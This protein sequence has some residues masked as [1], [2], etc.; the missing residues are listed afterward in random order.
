[1]HLSL[2]VIVIMILIMKPHRNEWTC[3]QPHCGVRCACLTFRH[4]CCVLSLTLS[5]IV[6]SVC[7]CRYFCRQKSKTKTV[8]SSATTLQRQV[9][10]LALPV[11]FASQKCVH[12]NHTEA[13]GALDS[14][15]VCLSCV[16]GFGVGSTRVTC[17]STIR[18][19]LR[20]HHR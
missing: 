15:A 17:S 14:P 20:L 19:W 13:S 12:L 6:S 10:H 4:L 3:Q 16:C 18:A 5:L 8:V 7:N 11:L 9:H 1:M 2:S